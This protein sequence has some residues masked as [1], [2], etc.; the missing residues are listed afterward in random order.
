MAF[1]VSGET[2]LLRQELYQRT[3]KELLLDDLIGTRFVKPITDFPDGVTYNIPSLGEATTFDMVEGVAVRYSRMDTGNFEFTFD[4][5]VGSASF[6]TEKFKRDSYW[7]S[8]VE[9]AFVPRQHRAIMERVEARILS[10]GPSGQTASNLNVINNADHRWIGSGTSESMALADF[11]KA[12]FAL[13]KA[14]VPMTDLVAIVDPT[15]TYSLMTQANLTNLLT[16]HPQWSSVVKD[17]LVTGMNF[18]F[19]IFGFDV[20][21][22]NYLPISLN[23]T[24]DG[25]TSADGVGNQFFSAAAGDTLPIIGGFR[26]F[27]KV[28][29]EYN[30]D[31]QQTE[32]VTVT[33]YGFALYRPEN[34]VVVITDRDVV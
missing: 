6:I 2:N 21:E 34:M 14:N 33:E 20:Y 4:Q 5:Y 7:S 27:P 9:S 13:T 24:I 17:G 32:Y 26:Q 19:N 10:R 29:I 18:R 15:V 28:D 31:L 22:S 12:R 30:K 23:E 3:L 1:S 25:R 16:P 11:A 8:D